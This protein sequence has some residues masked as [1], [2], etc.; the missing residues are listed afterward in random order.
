LN[1]V[2]LASLLFLISVGSACSSRYVRPSTGPFIA[3]GMAS[4]YGPE[5][6][7]RPTASG[8]KYDPNASTAAH[9]TLPF[10]TCVHVTN[11][12]NQKWIRVRVNDRG[13]FVDGRIIDLSEAAARHLG[14][15]KVGVL[16]VRLDECP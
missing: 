14:M 1:A 6:A 3:E 8:A 7:G 16:R 11:V 5:F 9:R 2:R 12:A 4:Y 13:P 10:G 15:M